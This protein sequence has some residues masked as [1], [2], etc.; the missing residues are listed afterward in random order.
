MGDRANVRIRYEDGQDIYFYTHWSGTEMPGT[1]AA[2][3]ARGRSRWDDESYLARILFCDLVKGDE[4]GL[5]GFGIA[6]Y[7]GDN[8]HPIL[9][10]DMKHRRVEI[11]GRGAWSFE[12]YATSPSL[13]E[14][15]K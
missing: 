13:A 14:V 9:T 3:L 5:T 6:P 8:E 7:I 11:E 15:E 10:V 1:V 12:E 2:S 4:L